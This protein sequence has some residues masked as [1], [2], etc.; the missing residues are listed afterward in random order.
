VVAAS[1]PTFL[2]PEKIQGKIIQPQR[3]DFKEWHDISDRLRAAIIPHT[4]ISAG[5]GSWLSRESAADIYISPEGLEDLKNWC[6]DEIDEK[7][8]I[9]IMRNHEI[10]ERNLLIYT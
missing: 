6:V 5:D 3:V 4:L 2:K 10:L 9:E 8:R 7:T 1:I